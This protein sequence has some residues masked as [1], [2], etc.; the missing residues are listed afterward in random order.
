MSFAQY[1][2]GD[3]YTLAVGEDTWD[4]HGSSWVDVCLFEVPVAMFS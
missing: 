3:G 1:L 4:G 2:S